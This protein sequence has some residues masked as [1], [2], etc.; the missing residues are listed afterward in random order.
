MKGGAAALRAGDVFRD[1]VLFLAA[2]FGAGLAPKA[3]GTAGTVVAIPLYL[4]LAGLAWPWRLGILG[5]AS[6]AG[7]VI[8]GSAARRLG[9]HDHPGIVWDEICGYLLTMLLAP[10]GVLWILA[11]FVF[12]RIFDIVK[13]WPVN[14]ADRRV[15]GGVGIMLD[16]LLA[17]AY[18]LAA[19]T[20]LAYLTGTQ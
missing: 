8:C 1:P 9:V 15:A 19:M 13:P 2:G 6:L 18:G 10:D 11:G 14:L 20:A 12:F 16:D 7:F 4:L 3:P 5:L 17:G